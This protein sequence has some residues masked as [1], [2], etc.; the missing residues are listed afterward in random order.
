VWAPISSAH[1]DQIDH[2]ASTPPSIQLESIARR[3]ILLA[4]NRLT[5]SRWRSPW[6]DVGRSIETCA[7]RAAERLEEHAGRE[8]D[9]LR[10]PRQSGF[11]KYSWE[12]YASARPTS[13]ARQPSRPD[14][15]SSA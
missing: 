15:T 6:R 10:I 3:E 2:E 8:G 12:Y 4:D 13:S 7:D 9:R 5:G 11:T 1:R 14:L